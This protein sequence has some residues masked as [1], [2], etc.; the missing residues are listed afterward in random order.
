MLKCACLMHKNKPLCFVC[1]LKINK[2]LKGSKQRE[3]D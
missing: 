3:D 2:G 1:A